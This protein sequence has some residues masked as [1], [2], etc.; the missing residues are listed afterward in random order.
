[1]KPES[2]Q[3]SSRTVPGRKR[4]WPPTSSAHGDQIGHAASEWWSITNPWPAATRW[5][6]A[7]A[8]LGRSGGFW[9][10]SGHVVVEGR[11]VWIVIRGHN[12]ERFGVFYPVDIE[13]EGIE[14]RLK[15][16]VVKRMPSGHS[17]NAHYISSISSRCSARFEGVP[18]C[19]HTIAIRRRNEL[20]AGTGIGREVRCC[21]LIARSEQVVLQPVA[22]IEK[23]L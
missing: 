9:T 10:D 14:K 12:V 13:A 7:V 16:G 4:Y 1:M 20:D 19:L 18:L 2:G 15:G 6:S 3:P 22:S 17:E 5:V 21:D 23:T 8:N 11:V